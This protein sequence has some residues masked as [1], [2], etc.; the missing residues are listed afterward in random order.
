MVIT[1]NGA[2]AL[3]YL[4][5]RNLCTQRMLGNPTVVLLNL[6]LP[7]V[8]RLE[9]LAEIQTTLMLESLPV[10]MLTSLRREVDLLRGYE[11]GINAYVVKSVEFQALVD[12]I[13]NLDIFWAVLNEPPSSS[14][15]ACRTLLPT[16]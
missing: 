8:G 3:D 10:V 14:T 12:A 6:K 5:A 2:K 1:H 15:W 4:H 7:K 11:L 13:V 9:V 16:S